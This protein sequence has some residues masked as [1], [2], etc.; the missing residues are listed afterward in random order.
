MAVRQMSIVAWRALVISAFALGSPA[1]F[2]AEMVAES[3]TMVETKAV[4]G[5]IES[6]NV[7]PARARIGG[8]IQSIAV[9]E[10]SEVK[11]GDVIAVVTDEKLA[12]QRDAAEAAVN[13]IQSQ[14]DNA[15][16]DLQRAVQLQVSGTAPQSRVDA[17][18]TQ[19]EVFTNQLAAAA[20]NRAVVEQQAHEGEV[21]APTTGRVL[22]VPVTPGSVILAG[23]EVA[24]IAGGGTFLRLSL[25]ERHAADIVEGD[26][27]T[28]GERV[29]SPGEGGA[30][31]LTTHPGRLAKIYPEIRDGRVEADVEVAGLGTYFV[32]QRT[33]VWI[34]VGRRSVIALPIAAITT[35]HGVDTVQIVT[36][37]GAVDVPVVI[38]ETFAGDQS[39]AQV[40]ILTGVHEGDRVLLP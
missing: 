27:V 24:Q 20:A 18:R 1:A 13:A 15:T 9:S 36:D 34:P 2:S 39:G 40:E 16:T 33:L 21:L 17:A 37:A 11:A 7:V 32:G 3:T 12:L 30:A 19:V 29:A 8:T 22:Q 25:P 28:V 26:A 5:L 10:G 35:R 31:A 4:F 23:E 14:L 6:R 38:G